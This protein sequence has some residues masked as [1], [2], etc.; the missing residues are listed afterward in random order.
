[1]ATANPTLFLSTF[2]AGG[3]E[4]GEGPDF[5]L[6]ERFGPEI[7]ERIKKLQ[8]LCE[9]EDLTEIRQHHGMSWLEHSGPISDELPEEVR[10]D[11]EEM[12]VTP[13]AFWFTCCLKNTDVRFETRPALLEDVLKRLEKNAD[14]P[15]VPVD[16]ESEDYLVNHCD[17]ID[18]EAL[19]LN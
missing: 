12:V 15:V 18:F 16:D 13:S 7:I 8:K 3:M 9:D 19:K 4:C 5:A 17:D 2:I 14:E 11:L 10:V 6:S 1:M